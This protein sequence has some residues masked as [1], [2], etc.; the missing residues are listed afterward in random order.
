MIR[1]GD[2]LFPDELVIC[3]GAVWRRGKKKIKKTQ[4]SEFYY[5]NH[6]HELEMTGVLK[7]FGEILRFQVLH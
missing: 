2:P 7:S 1:G 5:W 6:P 3:A 4:H